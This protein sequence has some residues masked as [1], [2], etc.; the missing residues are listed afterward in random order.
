MSA[1]HRTRDREKTRGKI[2]A[3]ARAEFAAKGYAGARMEQIAA[4]AGVNKELIYHYF[5]GKE[6]LFKEVRSEQRANAAAS[7]AVPRAPLGDD[8][9]QQPAELFAWRFQKMLAD[10]EWIKF[11]TWEAAQ[12]DAV[13]DQDARRATIRE[14]VAA[15][16]K[17]QKKSA[18]PAGLDPRMLQLAVFALATYPLAFSQITAMTTGMSAADKRFQ[19]AWVG[20]LR[21]LGVRLLSPRNAF[22]A[23]TRATA[24]RTDKRKPRL[25]KAARGK[26]LS[27]GATK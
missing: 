27:S 19:A 18:L 6:S 16:E 12:G 26:R 13:P 4:R 11:L 9:P 1:V 2:V 10:L 21:K 8:T 20:F 24:R 25:A 14:A 22:A 7:R 3:A 17:A 15:I 23:T 5:H